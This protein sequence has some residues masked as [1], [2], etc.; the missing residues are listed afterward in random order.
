MFLDNDTINKVGESLVTLS[1]AVS[2]LTETW[3]KFWETLHGKYGDCRE[4]ISYRAV[5]TG[6]QYHIFMNG[7]PRVRKKWYK[8]FKRRLQKEM[9]RYFQ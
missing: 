3:A 7:R 9:K 1:Q 8:V 5:A 2:S 6:R 4:T